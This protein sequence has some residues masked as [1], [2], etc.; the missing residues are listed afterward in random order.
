[1][2]GRA[3]PRSKSFTILVVFL[4]SGLAL[5]SLSVVTST[6]TLAEGRIYVPDENGTHCTLW[7][8]LRLR[9]PQTIMGRETAKCRRRAVPPTKIATFCRLKREYFDDETG[10]RMCVY[11]KQGVE[12]DKVVSLSPSLNCQRSFSCSVD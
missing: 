5:F 9:W 10:N 3:L 8:N 2:R 6:A 7:D 4:F 11:A 1:M 12:E